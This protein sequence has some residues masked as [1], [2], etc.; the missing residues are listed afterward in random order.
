MRIEEAGRGFNDGSD[1]VVDGDRVQVALCVGDD[2]HETQAHVLGVQVLSKGIAD[3]LGL[4]GL[5]GSVV[6][7]VGQV[8]HNGLVRRSSLG[9]D[10]RV[11]EGARD[12]GDIDGSVF[13]VGN[14][15]QRAGRLAVDQAQS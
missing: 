3:A 13:L 11:G 15:N 7:H 9:E 2:G 12:K 14:L 4:A 10:F 1:S 6:L 8:A 5:N